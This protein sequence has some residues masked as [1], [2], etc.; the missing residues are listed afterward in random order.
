MTDLRQKLKKWLLR[1]GQ[2]GKAGQSMT[3]ENRSLNLSESSQSSE[4]MGKEKSGES[5]K[6]G[7]YVPDI[8][9]PDPTKP[10]I[11]YPRRVGR[12]ER[13]IRRLKFFWNPPLTPA[14]KDDQETKRS[15]KAA[16]L[17][18]EADCR[19][20]N[21]KI[22]NS[23]A[24]MGIEYVRTSKNRHEVEKI[25][26]VQFGKWAWTVDG[27]T[28]YGKVREIPYGHFATELI[29]PRVLTQLSIAVGHP[30]R[31]NIDDQGGGVI[32]SV[33]LAGTLDIPTS[34]DFDYTFPLIS[35]SAPPMSVFVG[36]GENGA[37]HVYNL[38][39]L[40]HLLI[41]GTTGSG[42]SVMLTSILATIIARNSPKDIRLL[43][44]DLKQVDLTLFAGAPHLLTGEIPEI[45]NGIVEKDDQIIPLFK[46]LEKEN[47][48][49]QAI[50]A[51]QRIRNLAEWNR[52]NR[53]WHLPRI[54][55]AVDEFARLMRGEHLKKVFIDLT[56]DLA[57]TAR[58]TGIYLI[59]ATQ[60]AKDKYI[61]TDIKM[62]IPG[63]IAF[64]VPDLQGSVALIDSNQAVNL[65]PPAG[66]GIFAHGVNQ[67]KFQG[68]NISTAQ[69]LEIVKNAQ[70]GKTLKEISTGTDLTEDE[71]VR[72]SLTENNG[73][74]QTL[75]TFQHFTPR[76][77]QAPLKTM[78]QE[79][80]GKIYQIDGVEY[81][82]VPPA[83]GARGRKLEKIDLEK[84]SEDE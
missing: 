18:R 49:R 1:T 71:I 30:V 48:R 11:S 19:N 74:L 16:R 66:R 7:S 77:E 34:V 3:I 22:P 36:I 14:E 39:E 52:R 72:W 5:Q 20:L 55:V 83:G 6:G 61:T 46:W 67:F 8:E 53:K 10:R 45:P 59:L 4:G 42:K 47:N 51:H 80:D 24:S 78:L 50:F 2:H 82:V 17:R 43:L 65:Y 38:E 69:I 58:A 54:I 23:Y 41:G 27:A 32:V 25:Q 37:K 56:Y 70:L 68:P 60:F 84:E 33:S 21:K 12:L 75:N 44:A 62:N 63:R 73:Y 15:E 29:E 26:W 64:S 81:R 9:N 13:R 40:P 57:S 28:A 79:M 35:E 31:G 76:L